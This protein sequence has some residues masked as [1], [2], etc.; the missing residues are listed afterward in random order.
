[1][2][3]DYYLCSLIAVLALYYFLFKGDSLSRKILLLVVV[4]LILACKCF[5][6]LSLIWTDFFRTDSF[7]PRF[8]FCFVFVLIVCS[9][10]AIKDDDGEGGLRR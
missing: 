9:K 5:P 1:M 8:H 3:D 10:L 2:A 7:N 6:Y 4:S